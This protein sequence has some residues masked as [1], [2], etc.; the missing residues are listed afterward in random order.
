MT[1]TRRRHAWTAAGVGAFLVAVATAG[2]AAITAGDRRPESLEA[3]A[4][5]AGIS[6]AG[7][8]SGWLLERSRPRAAGHAIAAALG[9]VCLRVFPALAA[10]AWLQGA[11]GRLRENGA[12]GWLLVFYLTTLATDIFLHIIGHPGDRRGRDTAEN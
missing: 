7:G 3:I 6:L 8:L 10:L 11:G 4:F 9:A 12:A 5:A 1:L 2:G